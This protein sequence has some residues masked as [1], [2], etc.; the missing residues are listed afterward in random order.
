MSPG[1]KAEALSFTYPGEP[2]RPLSGWSG[3]LTFELA[4]AE[5]LHIAGPTGC[6]KSTLARCL[7]GLIPHLY[8]GQLSGTVWIG[9]LRS[10]QAPL[11]QL[12]EIAGL[13]FQNPAAQVLAPTVEEE[14][15]F[16]LENLGLDKAEIDRRVAQA[17]ERFGLAELH[18]RAPQTLSGGEQ[19]KLALAAVVA[20]R[21]PVLVLDEP[22]SMLDTTAAFDFVQHLA[23]WVAQGGA[24][25]ICEHR[26]EY[27]QSLPDLRLLTLDGRPELAPD[28]PAL[29]LPA[30]PASRIVAKGLCVERGGRPVLKDLDLTLE[31]G[32]ITAIVG[33]NG[34][35]KTTLL[36]ALAGLQPYQGDLVAWADGRS[37]AP[38]LGLVFQNPDLQL[39]N[40]TVR[41]EILYRLP[42]VDQ[43]L[44]RRLIAALDLERYE[45]TPP[46]LLSEGEKRRV[47]LATLLIRRPPH[48]VLLDEP[49]LGQDVA[50]K[51]LLM[52]LLQA[53]AR[54]GQVVALATHD[55]ELAACADR[56]ILL[57]RDGIVASGPPDQVLAER[58]AWHRLGLRLPEWVVPCPG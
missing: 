37:V 38:A 50:H 5:C 34:A 36:R 28:L 17:L 51:A 14:I 42:E 33:R 29:E 30:A 39:F 55:I 56:L 2:G 23:D 4:P 18:N 21:T 40:A 27:L 24:A 41:Q 25:A 31:G 9:D 7:T 46:L 20:R 48:G 57:D 12:S 10:D 35:G 13:V 52:R 32:Q 45:Q 49:A 16:G 15:I 3:L 53:V 47:A 11:W 6:G 22:L 1:L 8:H 54:Q 44:Y 58:S 19:Q 43:E 26:H